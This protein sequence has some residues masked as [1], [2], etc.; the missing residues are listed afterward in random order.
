MKIFFY[1]LRDYDEKHYL[2]ECAGKY[3]FEYDFTPEYPDMDNIELV[4]GFEGVSIITNPLDAKMLDR[5]KE[6]GVRY[7]M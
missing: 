5:M 1:A 6:L 2:E 4:K 7:I 3:G